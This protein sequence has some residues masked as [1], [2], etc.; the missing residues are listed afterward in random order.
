MIRRVDHKM[1]KR[2]RKLGLFSVRKIMLRGDIDE[3][4]CRGHSSWRCTVMDKKLWT[5]VAVRETLILG[6]I[7]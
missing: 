5:Q 6:R 3:I 1:V 2:L 7:N 4:L